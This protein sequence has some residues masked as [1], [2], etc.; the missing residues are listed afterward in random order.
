MDEQNLRLPLMTIRLFQPVA[1]TD[2]V[3]VNN[4]VNISFLENASKPEG[5][6]HRGIIL[7]GISEVH[8]RALTSVFTFTSHVWASLFPPAHTSSVPYHVSFSFAILMGNALISFSLVMSIIKHLKNMHKNLSCKLLVLS[9]ADFSIGLLVNGILKVRVDWIVGR[10]SSFFFFFNVDDFR[11]IYCIRYNIASVSCFGFL[12]MR[13]MGSEL[14][15]QGSNWQTLHWKLNTQALSEVT[16]GKSHEICF[17]IDGLYQIL[18]QS[19]IGHVNTF[20]LQFPHF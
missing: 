10:K 6:S 4:L 13:H 11:S 3:A 9:F 17:N 2:S 15:D 8:S 19:F 20:V 18:S 12:A 14:P 7:M 5:W 1:I 16:P